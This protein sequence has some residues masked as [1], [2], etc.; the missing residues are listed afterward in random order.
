MPA[1]DQL[2]GLGYR[3]LVHAAGGVLCLPTH[4]WLT[5]EGVSQP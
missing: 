5:V 2:R 1:F 4:S 3:L